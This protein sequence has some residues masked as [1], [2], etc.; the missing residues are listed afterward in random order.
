MLTT[1]IIMD[2]F[3]QEKA[4]YEDLFLGKDGIFEV[5]GVDKIAYKTTTGGKKGTEIDLETSILSVVKDKKEK[6]ALTGKE[7]DVI[8]EHLFTPYSDLL[9]LSNFQYDRGR[10][11]SVSLQ[12][13]ITG[14]ETYNSSMRTL[15]FNIAKDL[16][17]KQTD[18]DL[19]GF[20]DNATIRPNR[21]GTD[22]TGSVMTYDR[23]RRSQY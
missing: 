14:L 5:Y 8:Y 22:F 3:N 13:M 7:K 9:R 20:G 10:Q 17:V 1:D 23:L 4:I 16:G 11:K 6:A 19:F 12:D 18:I 21:N 2:C 15:Q